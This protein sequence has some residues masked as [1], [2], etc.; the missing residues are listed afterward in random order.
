M[1]K[2]NVS[3]LWLIPVIIMFPLIQIIVFL[4]RFGKLPENALSSSLS[5]IPLGLI[6][7]IVMILLL[8]YVDSHKKRKSIVIGFLIATPFSIIISLFACLIAPPIVA[9]SLIGT[10][11][12][13]I[14]II[15]GYYIK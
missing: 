9:N 2:K 8:N 6:S 4:S 15:T 5:F 1:N 3:Y 14:G 11:P 10:I 12:L 13:L 7:G